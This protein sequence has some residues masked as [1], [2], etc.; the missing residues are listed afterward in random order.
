[1]ASIERDLAD[2]LIAEDRIRERNAS[3]AMEIAARY[4]DRPLTVIIIT[5][6]ALMFGADLVRLLDIPLHLDTV[7][8]SSYIGT[9]SSRRVAVQ[10]RLKSSVSQRH[11]LIVDDIFDTGLTLSTIVR[12]LRELGPLS[13]A[14]CVLLSKQ[15]ERDADLQPDFIGFEIGDHFVVG[16]GLDYNETYRNLPCI[17]VLHPRITAET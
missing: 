4:R 15:R 17:G 5:N 3:L 7:S 6:G 9:R 13:V 10:S 1:M 14:T 16:Y 2:I 12:H 8:A 11:V